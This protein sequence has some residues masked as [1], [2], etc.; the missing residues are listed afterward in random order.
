MPNTP[1]AAT[2]TSRA[3]QSGRPTIP[4]PPHVDPTPPDL[5]VALPHGGQATLPGATWPQAAY[6]AH[7]RQARG[8]HRGGP[9]ISI[10]EASKREVSDLLVEWQHPLHAPDET[11]R[12]GRP[13][14]R[15]FCFDGWVMQAFG[16]PAAVMVSADPI[17]RV[18]DGTLG[19]HRRNTVELARICRAPD[20]RHQR[21]LVAALR[22]WRDYLAVLFDRYWGDGAI[23]AATTYSLPYKTGDLYRT[24]GFRRV[25]SARPNA[26]GGTWSNRSQ[27]AALA[28]TR[29]DVDDVDEAGHDMGLWLYRIPGRA[30]DRQQRASSDP[31]VQLALAADGGAS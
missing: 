23:V 6:E 20:Q 28:A 13:Y 18:V 1:T 26:G 9:V 7:N 8:G 5:H 4:R 24:C 15:P 17:N 3:P 27:T 2:R 30:L 22:L 14:R 19:L 10:I 25:R 21:C 31:A 12:A 29:R 16:Q 11:H